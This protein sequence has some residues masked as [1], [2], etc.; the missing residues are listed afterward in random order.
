MH[1]TQSQVSVFGKK[2]YIP[3]P[4]F[5]SRFYASFNGILILVSISRHHPATPCPGNVSP[6]NSREIVYEQHF[7]NYHC[8]A[9]PSKQ[10]GN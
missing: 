2:Y 9:I 5:P 1:P 6:Q 10:D 8:S 7:F 4:G 3:R